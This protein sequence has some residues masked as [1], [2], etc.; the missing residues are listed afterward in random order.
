MVAWLTASFSRVCGGTTPTSPCSRRA[1]GHARER[2]T[3]EDCVMA[4]RGVDERDREWRERDWRRSEEYGR[5]GRGDDERRFGYSQ[6]R[7][8]DRT[9]SG[10]ADDNG[11]AYED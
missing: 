10:A 3:R 5:G 1:G 7:G 4:D 9:W 2:H 8:E 6:G 11:G